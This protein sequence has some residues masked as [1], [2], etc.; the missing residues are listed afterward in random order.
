MY[1]RNNDFINLDNTNFIFDTNF[2]GD[3]ARDKYHD[4]RRKAKILLPNKETAERLRDMQIKVYETK[5]GKNDDPD[6]F[7][8]EYF[9]AAQAKFYYIDGTPVKEPPRIYLVNG[10]NEPVLLS[11]DALGLIDN[12]HVSNVNTVLN[13][14]KLGDNGTR[15]LYIKVM[16]VE[17]DITADPYA[18]Y[19]KNR[20]RSRA[21]EVFV[22]DD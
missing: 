8:P 1:N 20:A 4:S 15:P 19:Y 7:E 16:Y 10:N 12:I 2:S 17:Q 6:T 22:D 18:E 5:P 13:P 14:G 9:V 21:D 3:P 11:E